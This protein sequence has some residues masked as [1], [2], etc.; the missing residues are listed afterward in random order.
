MS[1]AS[2]LLLRHIETLVHDNAKWQTLISDDIQ[3]EL[4]YAP[5]IG[6]PARLSGQEEILHHVGWFLGAVENFR[7][8][9]A[10]VYPFDDPNSAVAEIKAEGII[11]PTGRPDHRFKRSGSS[12]SVRHRAMPTSSKSLSATKKCK[13]VDGFR[14][15]VAVALVS[16]Y[17]NG[18]TSEN[19]NLA[20][21][22]A[23]ARASPE[24]TA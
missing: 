8:F 24:F 10:R 16:S 3:W 13:K 11:K 12:V 1:T 19:Q 7:F 14:F 9:D 22:K 18:E 6:H 17:A 4:A 2:E 15:L 20:G 23:P 21:R 5:S